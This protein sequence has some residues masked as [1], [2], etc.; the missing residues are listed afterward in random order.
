M[1]NYI[2][3]LYTYIYVITHMYTYIYIYIYTYT[4][5]GVERAAATA[6]CVILCYDVVCHVI[7]YYTLYHIIIPLNY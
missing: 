7:A 3:I 1:Y 4:Y 2:H 5:Q 6:S